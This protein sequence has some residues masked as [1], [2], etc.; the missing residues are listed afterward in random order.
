MSSIEPKTQFLSALKNL[1]ESENAVAK[2]EADSKSSVASATAVATAALPQ[3]PVDNLAF[4]KTKLVGPTQAGRI[5]F[6]ERFRLAAAKIG[7]I[8]DNFDFGIKTTNQNRFNYTSFVLASEQSTSVNW[9]KVIL[10]NRMCE[11]FLKECGN[12][13]RPEREAFEKNKNLQ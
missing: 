13:T 11:E 10:P 6:Q 3:H 1:V 12:D 7:N 9:N 2:K 4:I 5:V 8:F